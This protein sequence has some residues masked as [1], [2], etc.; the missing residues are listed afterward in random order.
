MLRDLPTGNYAWSVQTIDAGYAGSVFAEEQFFTYTGDVGIDDVSYD[1]AD[2]RL[3]VLENVLVA[4]VD[5]DQ[6]LSVFLVDGSLVCKRL[7]RPGS[8]RIVLPKGIYIV[9]K[10]KV[11]IK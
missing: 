6:S 8:N 4:E 1:K 2:I 9:N 11:I 10:E 5:M 7:L 3:S